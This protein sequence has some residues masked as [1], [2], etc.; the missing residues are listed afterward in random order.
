MFLIR[1]KTLIYQIYSIEIGLQICKFQLR[2]C[3]YIYIYIFI[4]IY[5]HTSW[6]GFDPTL[7]RLEPHRR[8]V[9]Q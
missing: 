6:A 9:I 1:I 3:E 8:V 2:V 5:A 4:Y 7:K